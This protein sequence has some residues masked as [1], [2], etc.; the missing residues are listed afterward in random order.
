MKWLK[1]TSPSGGEV[2]FHK[3]RIVSFS[4]GHNVVINLED[5]YSHIV[6][7]EGTLIQ[8]LKK[9]MDNDNT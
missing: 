2:Y 6:K 9:L 4:I 8:N 1:A 3:S 5:G 7:A